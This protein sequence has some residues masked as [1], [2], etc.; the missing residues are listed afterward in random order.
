MIKWFRLLLLNRI[1]KKTIN[2]V[3]ETHGNRS[4]NTLN[5]ISVILDPLL[6]IDKNHFIKMGA[7]LN[8]KKNK[9]R[10]LT[11]YQSPKYLP[12]SKLDNCYTIKDIS[13]F[14]VLNGLL[15]DFCVEKSD[16]LINFYD[17]D[18]INLKFISA[19]TNKKLSIG[20]KS[21]DHS[22]ND[23][24]IE[25]DPQNIEVFVSECIKYLTILFTSKK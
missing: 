12:D 16:V 25:V 11:Y 18:D 2:A 17:K 7:V 24:I 1:Y 22:L 14:G 4:L 9:I 6:G 8:L 3:A 15:S 20:F 13:N 10:V 21:V 23:L 5:S 19:K